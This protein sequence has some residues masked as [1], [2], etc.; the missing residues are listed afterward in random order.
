MIG[1]LLAN[2]FQCIFEI[3]IL[4]VV[5]MVY[6]S[7][8][9]K[10]RLQN[11]LLDAAFDQVFNEIHKNIIKSYI[12]QNPA[13]ALVLRRL[14]AKCAVL[15]SPVH[16]KYYP[17]YFLIILSYIM[18]SSICS[19]NPPPSPPPPTPLLP[20]SPSA[21]PLLLPSPSFSPPPSPY[22]PPP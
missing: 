22:L 9:V 5:R 12:I 1:F 19:S 16:R 8:E 14:S 10:N 18:I 6:N 20:L 11:H 3:R 4:L 13:I 15:I 7:A 17:Y 2:I 21:F